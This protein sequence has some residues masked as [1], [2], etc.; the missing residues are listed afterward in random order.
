MKM[1]LFDTY[2]EN[3]TPTGQSIAKNIAH[4]QG[5]WHKAVH[6]WIM[7]DKNQLLLQKRAANLQFFPNLWDISA[8]GHLTA[9]QTSIQGARRETF[10]EL[11][12]NIQET[13][14]ELLFTAKDSFTYITP[15]TKPCKKI[16]KKICVMQGGRAQFYWRKTRPTTKH[17]ANF[18]REDF[19][20]FSRWS[21]INNSN[22]FLKLQPLL[23]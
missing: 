15:P 23:C 1:E 11:G 8:A 4:S 5:L 14:L 17:N 20:S 2:H 16:L 22:H 9:G 18:R 10:E 12:I 3:G 6:I 21:N 19:A 7:N 13:Q